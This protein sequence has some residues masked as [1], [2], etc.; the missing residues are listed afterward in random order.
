MRC[1]GFAGLACL[2]FVSSALAQE[3]GARPSS[4][5]S[6]GAP[7]EQ[8]LGRAAAGAVFKRLTQKKDETPKP[9]VLFSATLTAVPRY[10]N[11]TGISGHG[12][13]VTLDKARQNSGHVSEEDEE[14]GSDS[15]LHGEFVWSGPPLSVAHGG[16]G[17]GD[18]VQFTLSF[19][20]SDRL[21]KTL[22]KGAQT[23]TGYALTARSLGPA[24]PDL[25]LTSG[26]GKKA[27]D[28]PLSEKAEVRT[29]SI[30][31]P[32]DKGA[33]SNRDDPAN[34]LSVRKAPKAGQNCSPLA[35]GEIARG[36]LTPT[37]SG[38]HL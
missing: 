38:E 8:Q 37:A 5:G 35:P 11:T 12:G 7:I 2:A 33:K 1:S 36:A 31:N 14:H 27:D 32:I 26:G 20:R 25:C 19:S 21:A 24:S 30:V 22:A 4:G 29:E 13:A 9:P 17:S 28:P 6:G 34:E 15:S 16:T 10:I 18:R 3:G 23:R